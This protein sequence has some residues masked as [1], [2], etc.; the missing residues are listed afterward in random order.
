MTKQDQ[1]FVYKF[2]VCH[3]IDSII[4]E[5]IRF[6]SKQPALS[7]IHSFFSKCQLNTV[8]STFRPSKIDFVCRQ[9]RKV[10]LCLSSSGRS[11]TLIVLRLPAL[12]II[13]ALFPGQIFG[14]G[15]K[16]FLFLSLGTFHN[17][18]DELLQ[19]TVDLKQR[20]PEMMQKIDEKPLNVGAIVILI[21]HD[22]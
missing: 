15:K 3:G 4:H 12:A 20:R 7:V 13:S 14:N 5:S 19:E 9:V 18:S 1:L 11:Q 6:H 17:R 10:L 16:S 21:S 2:R 8:T 22:H